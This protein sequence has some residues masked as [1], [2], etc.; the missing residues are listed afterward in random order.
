MDRDDSTVCTYH[1]GRV[2]SARILSIGA[3]AGI[4]LA[5]LTH[6][7]SNIGA[8][9]SVAVAIVP[10]LLAAFT[11][12][13]KTTTAWGVSMIMTIGSLVQVTSNRRRWVLA[14]SL[15]TLGCGSTAVLLGAFLG[16][17]GA[18]ARHAVCG[19]WDCAAHPAVSAASVGIVGLV[20]VA[21][22]CSDA[23]YLHLPRPV[24]FNAVPVTWWRRWQ[25][26][27]AALAYGAALGLGVT[28]RIPFGAFYALCA[29]CLLRG[30]VAYGMVLFGIYGLA[31]ALTLIP[32]SYAVY[33]RRQGEQ[34]D[35]KASVRRCV[36]LVE[37]A[38]DARVILA[39]LLIAF[40]LQLIV[41]SV[42]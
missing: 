20:A 9:I 15:Y 8:V 28:T 14:A 2:A 5:L 32:A 25:P 30:D 27:G 1:A 16:G 23:G 34:F 13:A 33:R 21:Y 19:T 24:L 36:R 39:V 12:M 35:Q 17:I 11:G 37:R 4:S 26:Y 29:W 22:A 3:V 6:L 42:F 10:L 7:P 18:L 31:R 38:S 41:S 40:G